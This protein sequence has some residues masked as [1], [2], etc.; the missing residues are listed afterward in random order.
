MEN[1]RWASIITNY[2]TD[3]S[4]KLG[5]PIINEA[6]QAIGIAVAAIF[7]AQNVG[8]AIPINELKLIL[9]N[10]IATRFVRMP[11]LGFAFIDSNDALA[12]HLGNPL[13]A[14]LYINR[15][16]PLSLAA[17]AGIEQGDMLYELNGMKV[18]AYGDAIVRGQAEKYQFMIS[19][20]DFL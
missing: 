8:Y 5:G 12:S 13:P 17:Q 1:S 18:D 3:K 19:S 4:R 2:G 14:G 20:H 10:F 11:S 16:L 6:G 15:V 9:E 7:P